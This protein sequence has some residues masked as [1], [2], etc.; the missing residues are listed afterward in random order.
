[1][2]DFTITFRKSK[3]SETKTFSDVKL[4]PIF[5]TEWLQEEP[6]E[7]V[8]HNLPF[9][10]SAPLDYPALFESMQ[11]I[12]CSILSSMPFETVKSFLQKHYGSSYKGIAL[13]YWTVFPANTDEEF[14]FEFYH[15]LEYSEDE[16]ITT[17]LDDQR[18][19]LTE[20]G[21]FNFKLVGQKLAITRKDYITKIPGY[22]LYESV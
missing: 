12:T 13:L 1:M 3:T 19:C 22:Y 4:Y 16:F 10:L 17:Y 18:N 11:S 5:V 14:A 9:D 8:D 2:N 20:N 15:W 6:Y 7:I 21:E